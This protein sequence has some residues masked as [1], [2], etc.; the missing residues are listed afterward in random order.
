MSTSLSL[1]VQRA[2]YIRRHQVLRG[3]NRPEGS[4]HLR[5]L[6]IECGEKSLN[7]L[8]MFWLLIGL[9]W[10]CYDGTRKPSK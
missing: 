10:P 7:V 9:V 8:I 5:N 1:E 2:E 6:G 3:G 4:E